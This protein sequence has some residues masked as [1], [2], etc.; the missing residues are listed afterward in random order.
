[1]QIPSLLELDPETQ[2][3][4]G[5]PKELQEAFATGWELGYEA[6]MQDQEERY[7]TFRRNPLDR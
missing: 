1:M 2:Q 7:D 6:G 3:W 5:D 4:K